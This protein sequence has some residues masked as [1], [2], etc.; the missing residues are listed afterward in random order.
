MLYNL[1]MEKK[2]LFLGHHV[3][4]F[5]AMLSRTY[6]AFEHCPKG[7]FY[8]K[9]SESKIPIGSKDDGKGFGLTI[10]EKIDCLL[11]MPKRM[12]KI[13]GKLDSQSSTYESIITI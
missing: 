1:F 6:R 13:K 12:D 9:K 11:N 10:A 5:N 3:A 2:L 4:F 7:F 8:G